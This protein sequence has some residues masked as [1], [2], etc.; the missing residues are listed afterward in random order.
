M[1]APASAPN[2]EASD[3]NLANWSQ[4]EYAGEYRDNADCYIQDRVS[5][6]HVAGSF[7]RYFLGKAPHP[8][9][10]DLGCGDGALAETLHRVLPQARL[11]AAD[12]SADMIAAARVRLQRI[13]VEFHAVSFEEMIAGAFKP[14]P[15]DGIFSS[16]AIHHLPLA[17]KAAL[18]R[19]IHGLLVPAG[20][21]LNIDVAV[22][23]IPAHLEWHYALWK[24]WIEEE[25]RKAGRQESLAHVPARARAKDE[26]HF[27]PLAAQL[28]AL[29]EAGFADVECHY[30][31]GMFA[32]YSGRRDG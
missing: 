13:P 12:G 30:R 25:E 18:F 4:P 15:F 24:E 14:A 20:H 10:L 22:S 8:R 3:N 11:A 5:L 6:L 31:Y 16:L 29:Q 28:A 27:D 32:A 21:F 7:A 1:S 2:S 17:Q 19:A 23:G 9:L 26:N